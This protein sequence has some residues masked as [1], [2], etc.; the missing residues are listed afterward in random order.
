LAELAKEKE[1]VDRQTARRSAAITRQR[2]QILQA[3]EA[4][5]FRLIGRTVADLTFSGRIPDPDR[6][7]R[8]EE[9]AIRYR[10]H[11]ER[12]E[13]ERREAV[14]VLYNHSFI[15]TQED[16]DKTIEEKFVASPPEFRG[17]VAGESVWDK[18][19]PR[20]VGDMV[21]DSGRDQGAVRFH[22]ANW[23]RVAKRMKKIGDVLTGGS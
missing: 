16:L 19:S 11:V 23:D 4:E 6:A 9:K 17:I 13:A 15:T 21:G 2:A 14:Q 12:K 18:E 22:G 7:R 1:E 10:Q 3:K 8:L 20:T 5:D